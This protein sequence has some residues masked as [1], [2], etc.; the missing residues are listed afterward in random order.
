[1]LFPILSFG[2][3]FRQR[4]TD[5]D[6]QLHHFFE[7]AWMAHSQNCATWEERGPRARAT[8]SVSTT[9]T[10]YRVEDKKIAEHCGLTQ[11]VPSQEK[12]KNNNG[13]L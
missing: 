9:A 1:M 13:M 11:E 5:V 7:A 6:R 8:F 10:K 4:G 2:W 3:M 12:W